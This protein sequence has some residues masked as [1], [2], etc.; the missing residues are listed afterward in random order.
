MSTE[1]IDRL[2]ADLDH[3]IE[4]LT[5][6]RR[7]AVELRATWS[8]EPA[9]A[10]PEPTEGEPP[11]KPAARKKRLT[12]QKERVDCPECGESFL[13]NGLGP[14]RK[15]KHPEAFEQPK[16]VLAAVPNEPQIPADP[17]LRFRCSSCTA[18]TNTREALA[19][20]T[21][22]KHRRGLRPEEHTARAE[23]VAS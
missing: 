3:D 11:L 16:P 4:V 15:R 17:S 6:R 19:R 14:H 7:L 8:D 9:A 12:K 20:H 5:E 21:D 2:I 22:D 23:A 18:A 1:L 13:R 10:T